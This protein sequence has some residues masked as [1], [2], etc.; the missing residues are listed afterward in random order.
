M[1]LSLETQAYG[2]YVVVVE[3]VPAHRMWSS[4]IP[5][6]FLCAAV[7]VIFFFLWL[8]ISFLSVSNSCHPI[9]AWGCQ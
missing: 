6:Q 2:R 4:C 3:I 8:I 7:H 1:P 5:R 9:L